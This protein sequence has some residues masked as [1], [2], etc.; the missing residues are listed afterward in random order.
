MNENDQAFNHMLMTLLTRPMLIMLMTRDMMHD[1][2][3]D[4]KNKN[5]NL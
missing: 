2:S 5:T 4:I 1:I 3:N